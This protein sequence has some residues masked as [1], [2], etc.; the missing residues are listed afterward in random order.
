MKQSI[1]QEEKESNNEFEPSMISQKSKKIYKGTKAKAKRQVQND[2]KSKR[3]PWQPEED[4]Q[5]VELVNKYGSKWAKIASFLP[6]RTGKQVRDRYTNKL[7]PSINKDEWTEKEERLFEQLCKQMGNKWSQIASFLPGRTE[8]Q[9]KNRFYA[10][11]RKKLSSS[12][13]EETFDSTILLQDNQSE[14]M[15]SSRSKE[16]NLAQTQNAI[17]IE[18]APPQPKNTSQIDDDYEIIV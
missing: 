9:V 10:Q 12:Q 13:K 18:V 1:D 6:E 14:G 7:R 16:P 11:Y 3:K 8:G 15:V 17:E 5:V 4:L 2:S